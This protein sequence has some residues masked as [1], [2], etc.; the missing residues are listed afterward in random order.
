MHHLKYIDVRGAAGTATR[1]Y[2]CAPVWPLT[3]RAAPVVV[4]ITIASRISWTLFCKADFCSAVSL[5]DDGSSCSLQG[6]RVKQIW[7]IDVSEVSNTIISI[8]CSVHPLLQLAHINGELGICKRHFGGLR[9]RGCLR[10]EKQRLRGVERTDSR[11]DKHSE[12][13]S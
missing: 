8:S 7:L 12:S 4:N 13:A 2:A 6:V 9:V 3:P 11:P 5:L 1:A 10:W